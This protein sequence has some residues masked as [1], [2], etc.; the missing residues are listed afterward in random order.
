MC[1][2][3]EIEAVQQLLPFTAKAEAEYGTQAYF[4]QPSARDAKLEADATAS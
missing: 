4:L 2:R 1:K 3:K